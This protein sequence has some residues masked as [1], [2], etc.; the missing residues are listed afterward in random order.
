MHAN[1]IGKEELEYKLQKWKRLAPLVNTRNKHARMFA[2]LLLNV[3]L[4]IGMSLL[5]NVIWF[6]QNLLK[7]QQIETLITGN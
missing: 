4:L 5:K 2:G 3:G 6:I 7:H 1:F